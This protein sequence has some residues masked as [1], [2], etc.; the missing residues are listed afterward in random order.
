M[1]AKTYFAND[2]NGIVTA[3]V[4]KTFEVANR[5]L[6]KY[7]T[8]DAM[9]ASKFWISLTGQTEFVF[10]SCF[11]AM[12]D[13]EG[14]ARVGCGGLDDDIMAQQAGRVRQYGAQAYRLSEKQAAIVL[15]AAFAYIFES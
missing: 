9:M 13:A 4:E 2:I 1:D 14:R 5:M 6:D 7:T 11:Q 3:N 15:K 12:A 8:V 10:L